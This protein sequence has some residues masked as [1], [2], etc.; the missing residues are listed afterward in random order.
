MKNILVQ[1]RQSR[2]VPEQQMF[3]IIHTSL[4][5]IFSQMVRYS[6][7][8]CILFSSRKLHCFSRYSMPLECLTA[9]IHLPLSRLADA[10]CSGKCNIAYVNPSAAYHA[11]SLRS[12]ALIQFGSGNIK[13]RL[14]FDDF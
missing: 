5:E 8:R 3:C 7:L 12:G 2:H 10:A 1:R 11:F 14:V 13:G 6:V 9:S 4:R